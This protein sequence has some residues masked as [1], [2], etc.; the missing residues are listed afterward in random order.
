MALFAILLFVWF[1]FAALVVDMGVASL[2]AAR[3]ETAADAGALARLRDG[4]AASALD[5][6]F[7]ETGGRPQ[8]GFSLPTPI[9]V[10]EDLDG[11]GVVDVGFEV[12]TPLLFGQGT[13]LQFAG[14]RSLDELRAARIAGDAAPVLEM[15]RLRERGLRQRVTSEASLHPV[16]RVGASVV[17]ADGVARPGRANFA[18]RAACWLRQPPGALVDPDARLRARFRIDGEGALG[19]VAREAATAAAAPDCEDDAGFALSAA[20][21]STWVGD[22]V[23]ERLQRSPVPP[24]VPDAAVYVPLLDDEG[25][26]LAFARADAV[27]DGAELRVETDERSAA[28]GNASAVLA[29]GDSA[30]LANARTALRT[31]DEWLARDG[32]P[33]ILRAPALSPGGS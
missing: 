19:L 17:D 10:A 13:L 9:A 22:A 29:P 5:A 12:A 25:V 15:G 24:V 31:R 32:D 11:D 30:R 3:L 4:G 33:G 26:V 28:T 2:V 18:V 27:F 7:A 8:A 14:D 23:G 6:A 1:G 21:G 16:L 20:R